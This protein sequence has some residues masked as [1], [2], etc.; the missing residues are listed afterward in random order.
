MFCNKCGKEID[1]N[2]TVCPNC[3]T[4]VEHG[5]TKKKKSKKWLIIVIIAVVLVIII[6]AIGSSGDEPTSSGSSSVSNQVENENKVFGVNEAVT[7]KNI[8][9]TVT[10]IKKSNGTEFD[11]PKSGM[12]YVIVTV[13]YKNNSSS[14]VSY[15]PYDF[16]MKN[17]K[18]QI[19]DHTFTTVDND[20]S[21][22]SGELA[23][24]GE[25]SGTVVFEQPI[26][27]SDLILQYFYNM[28]DSDPSIEFKVS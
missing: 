21:L 7:Y 22:L 1:E 27:D 8:E 2:S 18:G 25:I 28:L 5:K 19:V 23:P 24:G 26:N 13:K 4:P 11:S 3:A 6:G 10:D 16:K 20:T 15:N 14:T 17:S 12:E 9:M